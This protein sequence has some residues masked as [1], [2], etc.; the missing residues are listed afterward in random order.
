MEFTISSSPFTL[1]ISK[2]GL[3]KVLK[4]NLDVE[5]IQEFSDEFGIISRNLLKNGSTKEI[6]KFLRNCFAI[7]F[8]VA[9]KF[10]V[11]KGYKLSGDSE[12]KFLE[13]LIR[14]GKFELGYQPKLSL[15]ELLLDNESLYDK[16]MAFVKDILFLCKT[17]NEELKKSETNSL[18]PNPFRKRSLSADFEKGFFHPTSF[19]SPPHVLLRSKPYQQDLLLFSPARSRP[20]PPFFGKTNAF[21]STPPI[22]YQTTISTKERLLNTGSSVIATPITNSSNN[23]NNNL[24]RVISPKGKDLSIVKEK[25]SSPIKSPS[26]AGQYSKSYPSPPIST[27][28]SFYARQYI[29]VKPSMLLEEQVNEQ[30]QYPLSPREI[31]I[32]SSSYKQQQAP[33]HNIRRL[34]FDPELEDSMKQLEARFDQELSEVKDRMSRMEVQLTEITKLLQSL[35]RSQGNNNAS[36]VSNSSIAGNI[37]GKT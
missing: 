21:T 12:V 23:N 4:M 19:Q 25:I 36:I 31:A 26:L 8:S 11:E 28:T 24:N 10:F 34:E 35:Q 13:T 17:K 27:S 7:V 18:I 3:C 30:Q 6:C 22:V 16:K 5:A 37:G 14:L 2:P 9:N 15:Q 1:F 32:D 29:P 20:V 33:R